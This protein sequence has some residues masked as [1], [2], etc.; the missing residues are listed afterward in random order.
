MWVIKTKGQTYYVHHVEVDKG[1]GFSTKET[2]DNPSTFT[3]FMIFIIKLYVM[4]K[5]KTTKE[6]IIEAIE[7]H[8]DKYLYDNV[9]YKTNHDKIEVICKEHGLFYVRPNDHLSKKSGCPICAGKNKTTE[10]FILKAK[11]IHGDKFTYNKSIYSSVDTDIIIT[12]P[13]HGEFKQTPY[14]HLKGHGCKKCSC[15]TMGL[16]YRLNNEIFIDKA[17]KIH[18]DK[19]SYEKVNYE[20]TNSKI[21][22]KCPIHGYFTQT[23]SSHLNGRGCP[24]CK[25]SKGE[26]RIRMWLS[27]NKINFI[28]QYKFNN[29][30]NPKTKRK[31]PFDFYLPEFNACI[32]FQGKQ[33]FSTKYGG[34]GASKE[35]TLINFEK[36]KYN[37]KIK[38]DFCFNNKIELIEISYLDKVEDMLSIKFKGNVELITENGLIIAKITNN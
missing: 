36:L 32:E 35:N 24:I 12:C 30:T 10:E 14:T 2:P 6:F 9:I 17:K 1:V 21:I 20:T 34:F 29:C 26:K 31:L 23:P 28:A 22:I 25:E 27:D 7:V 8:G 38:S 19:F 18:G 33:H 4:S 15:K 3:D 13:T 16:K 37:D 11:K 5:K